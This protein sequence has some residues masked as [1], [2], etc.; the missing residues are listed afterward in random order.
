MSNNSQQD[1]NKSSRSQLGCLVLFIIALP[2]LY[3]LS[4]GPVFRLF[5]VMEWDI[6]IFRSIYT[7]VTWLH[8][9]TFLKEPIEWYARLF[10]RDIM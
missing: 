5:I 3:L 10:T 2:V 4:S 8:E 9:N 7:P 6:E 1:P